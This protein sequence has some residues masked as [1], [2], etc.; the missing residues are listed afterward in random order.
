MYF[1]DWCLSVNDFHYDAQTFI[2]R[3]LLVIYDLV[4]Q[5]LAYSTY[6][7]LPLD[8]CNLESFSIKSPHLFSQLFSTLFITFLSCS[9]IHV[10]PATIIYRSMYLLPTCYLP[11]TPTAII[12]SCIRKIF[13]SVY[14]SS[15]WLFGTN[16][17][18]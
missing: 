3:N 7:V 4:L 10:T 14:C 16:F 6:N 13:R 15:F 17:L 8:C 9:H 5:N 2:G 1:F 12:F 18:F 11:V